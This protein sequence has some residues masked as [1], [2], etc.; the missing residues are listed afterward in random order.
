VEEIV[1]QGAFLWY[2]LLINEADQGYRIPVKSDKEG[3]AKRLKN[4]TVH[5]GQQSNK[6]QRWKMSLGRMVLMLL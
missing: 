4:L 1:E 3:E 6:A 5:G 2:G